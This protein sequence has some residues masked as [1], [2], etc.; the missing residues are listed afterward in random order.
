[1]DPLSRQLNGLYPKV[2]VKTD[3]GF[4]N[5]N[6]LLF[7]D[8][9]KL[10]A[11]D[12]ITMVAMLN[13]TKEFFT[14]VGLEI[15]KEKSATNSQSCSKEALLLEGLKGYKY[16]GITESKT[17]E[18][19][20]ESLNKI[21]SEMIRRTRKLCETKLYAKN[22]FK[23]INEHAISLINYH[24]GV[25]KLAP[26]DYADIDDEIRQVLW[27]LKSTYNLDAKRDYIFPENS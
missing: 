3:Q 24:I 13:Q 22:L 11:K 18:V 5:T 19:S 21:K 9:L 4:Y 6:H 23:A 16:L 8:D 27:I 1:M 10:L 20:P 14:A 25:L 17:S 26:K 15:N 2:S 7:I 12:E